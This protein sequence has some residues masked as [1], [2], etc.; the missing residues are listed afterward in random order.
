METQRGC[1]RLEW[2]PQ[3]AAAEVWPVWLMEGEGMECSKSVSP[4][5]VPHR[6][7]RK[8]SLRAPLKSFPSLKDSFSSPFR[9]KLGEHNVQ[10]DSC[11]AACRGSCTMITSCT[12]AAEDAALLSGWGDTQDNRAA[13]DLDSRQTQKRP[14]DFP[15]KQTQLCLHSAFLIEKHSS[16]TK[17][18]KPFCMLLLFL[19]MFY[20]TGLFPAFCS[21]TAACLNP[22]L[23]VIRDC[24]SFSGW[25]LTIYVST[26]IYM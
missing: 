21:N 17:V 9:R 19:C 1:K 2:N 7:Q 14:V 16:V 22:L 10:I 6:G 23:P 8:H 13:W 25:Q 11:V 26:Y 20:L 4:E 18:L 5:L 3:S 24:C 15:C 12:P